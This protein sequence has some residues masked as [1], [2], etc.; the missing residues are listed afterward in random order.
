MFAQHGLNQE[1]QMS[2][3]GGRDCGAG[4]GI[5]VRVESCPL[6]VC[7]SSTEQQVKRLEGVKGGEPWRPQSSAERNFF[8]SPAGCGDVEAEAS[9]GLTL[10]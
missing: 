7:R 3:S 10:T 4:E 8:C 6:K 5:V 1:E 2:S 9:R